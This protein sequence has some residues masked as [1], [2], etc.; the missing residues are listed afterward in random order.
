MTTKTIN[1]NAKLRSKESVIK[2]ATLL[3]YSDI[4]MELSG[5]GKCFTSKSGKKFVCRISFS[6]GDDRY[7]SLYIQ[8]KG[9]RT[10][11]KSISH[12][13]TAEQYNSLTGTF[14]F[15]EKIKEL[16]PEIKGRVTG[17]A[18]C[19]NDYHFSEQL[20][21]TMQ[22]HDTQFGEYNMINFDQFWCIVW[23]R[24]RVNYAKRIAKEQE[25]DNTCHKCNGTGFI[26]QFAWYA[27]GV[28]FD[29]LGT[30]HIL[31]DTKVIV[32]I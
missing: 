31:N 5:F 24:I 7:S 23:D 18:R 14:G 13:L 28:C 20:D 6:F 19:G 26:P 8:S 11:P 9:V 10:M 29:C 32:E 4:K 22:F 1:L 12:P 15:G 27:D 2:T 17:M 3:G 21:E 25:L 16:Y 30:G